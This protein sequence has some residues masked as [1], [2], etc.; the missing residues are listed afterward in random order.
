MCTN[1]LRLTLVPMSLAFLLQARACLRAGHSDL[2]IRRRRRRQ[3]VQPHG[4]VQDLCWSDFEDVINGEI[5]CLDPGGFGAVTI[6]RSVTIDC[7]EIFASILASGTNGI[8]INVAAGNANDP[9]ERCGCAI[10]TSM[11]PARAE[12]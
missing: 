11:A 8:N 7:H 3:S 1:S 12:P 2:G 9:S 5:N 6:T 4:A 10:S